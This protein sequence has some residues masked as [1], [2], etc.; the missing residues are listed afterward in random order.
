MG[1]SIQ[2]IAR[3]W[4]LAVWLLATAAL[5][6][7]AD[8][9]QLED[10]YAREE[11]ARIE[12]LARLIEGATPPRHAEPLIAKLLE[13]S[14]AGRHRARWCLVALMEIGARAD[15]YLPQY[16]AAQCWL[17]F[18]G[19]PP[20]A[21][22][23]ERRGPA[24][25]PTRLE[26]S[27]K[28][29]QRCIRRV[30]AELE[31]ADASRAGQAELALERMAAPVE[32]MAP[33]LAA[34]LADTAKPV[35]ARRTAAVLLGRYGRHAG[36][37]AP[38]LA[39]LRDRSPEIR[40]VCALALGQLRQPY[41]LFGA[42]GDAG[43]HPDAPATARGLL[44]VLKDSDPTVSSAA[45]ASLQTLGP[46]AAPATA[47]V[48]ALF[49]DS[50]ARLQ[51]GLL[52]ALANWGSG[53]ALPAFAQ[54]LVSTD[55][56]ARVY[57]ATK[58]NRLL[59][60]FAGDAAAL[61]GI[62]VALLPALE[63]RLRDDPA[64]TVEIARACALLGARVKSLRAPLL[65]A[66]KEPPQQRHLA[67]L[68]NA[69]CRVDPDA[70]APEQE[71]LAIAADAPTAEVREELAAALA[72][73]PQSSTEAAAALAALLA[74]R[75]VAVRLRAIAA[76]AAS[77]AADHTPVPAVRAALEARREDPSPLVRKAAAALFAPPETPPSP[78][79]SN[80]PAP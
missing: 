23:P 70:T 50:E 17:E 62:A 12:A 36:S 80:P 22:S 78:A 19:T 9:V 13:P 72:A 34:A 37:V 57:A 61:D 54:M 52:A 20:A 79:P 38:L 49:L 16:F 44:K 30:V 48:T 51:D 11:S 64:V 31:A 63:P 26:L 29:W 67:T 74:D 14:W 15:E 77:Q 18:D 32:L 24:L 3:W 53:E 45:M 6:R 66:L 5:A 56:A 46:E 8:E 68:F 75:D 65:A 43:T 69:V 7:A 41:D 60:R 21:D 42:A 47:E 55:V 76:I 40:A 39:G 33:I 2:R 27:Q 71:L 28:V 4:S 35:R 73:I 1:I 59:L 10:L 25:P 58:L